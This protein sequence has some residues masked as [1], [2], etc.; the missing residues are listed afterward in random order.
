M[1]DPL[2]IH[3]VTGP[4]DA[5]V[6]LPGSKSITN[7]ALI[8]AA[9]ADGTSRLEDALFSDDTRYMAESL[10]RLGIPVEADE[11]AHSFAVHG[12]SGTIPA[13][14]ADLYVGNSGT[15]AR[16]LTALVVLGQGTYRIDGNKR[17]RER[18]IRDLLDSLRLFGVDATDELGTGS[19]PIVVQAHGFAGGRTRI[20]GD[21]SSQYLSGLLMVAPLSSNGVEIKIDG[22]LYSIPYVIITL[23][24]MNGWGAVFKRDAFQRFIIPANQT[25]QAQTYAIEP[26][27]SAA[28]YF[29]AAAAVTGGR[30]VI[31]GLGKDSMQGDMGFLNI[32]SAMGC[33]I[34]RGVNAVE[35]IG[36]SQLNGLDVT[37]ND[38]SDTVM[39]LAAIAPFADSPINISGIEHIRFKETDRISAV[40]NELR[41][42]GVRVDERPDGLKIYPAKDIQPAEIETYDDHRMA[43][44][45][46]ITGL[47]APGISIKNPGCVSKT[48]PNFWQKLEQIR[49]DRD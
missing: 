34:S 49:S 42:I 41:R 37:M 13:T 3:P 15:S 43:M 20:R 19:P 22:D 9:L 33:R 40:T 30:M 17:M 18:P 14:K 46:A 25:Y 1:T 16:F 31:R 32:L 44:S 4:I 11:E 21:V 12:Q 24:M 26:D 38:I 47:K 28:S 35:V 6:E 45:F 2:P 29:F 8:L 48:F 7:R 23:R 36:P 27:A 5:T 10:N 39:T